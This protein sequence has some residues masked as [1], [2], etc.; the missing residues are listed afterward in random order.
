[1]TYVEGAGPVPCDIA[2][3]GEAPGHKECQELKPFVPWAPAGK[4]FAR[5][6]RIPRLQRENVY[7]TNLFKEP[8][9]E[10]PTKD[11]LESQ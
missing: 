1:M 9:P 6:L 3:I 11:D 4:E 5:Y 7:I 8:I 2:F 10:N